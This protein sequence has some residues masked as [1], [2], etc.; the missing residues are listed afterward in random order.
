MGY[1]KLET[2]TWK[3]PLGPS[4][5]GYLRNNI[6]FLQYVA[7]AEHIISTGEHNAREIPRVVRTIS[8]TTVYPSSSDI[9][10]VT[11]PSAGKYVLT[12]ASGR[13]TAAD[14]RVQLSPIDTAPAVGTFKVNSATEIEVHL[15]RMTATFGEGDGNSWAL[16][17]MPFCIAIHSTPLDGGAWNVLP[18]PFVR[19]QNGGGLTGFETSPI[20]AWTRYVEEMDAVQ[21]VLVVA[22][23]TSGSHNVQQVAHTSALVTW[24]GSAYAT[25]EPGILSVTR[26]SAGYIELE[27]NEA[28][29]YQQPFISDLGTSSFSAPIAAQSAVDEVSVF[30]FRYA[31]GTDNWELYDG[32]FFV[33][34][35]GG[36]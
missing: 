31:E 6:S 23:G 22:H 13:F 14:I 29:T 17:N 10:T 19:G 32:S 33:A 4:Y 34:I 16:T 36:A 26:V 2:K 15:F 3:D 5:L 7:G 24:D 30:L 20:P 12:L 21:K 25:T 8:G 27:L 1:A 18:G 9:T 11:N 35:H 28:L